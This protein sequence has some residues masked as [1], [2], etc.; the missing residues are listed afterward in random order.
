MRAVVFLLS[1]CLASARL[2]EGKVLQLDD[3]LVSVS[4]D[5]GEENCGLLLRNT[6]EL[7]NSVS[8]TLYGDTEGVVRLEGATV[9]LPAGWQCQG[10]EV[11]EEEAG[12]GDA[13]VE[14]VKYGE[15]PV[16][17]QW[18]GCGTRGLAVRLPIESLTRNDS[19]TSKRFTAEIQNYLFGVFLDAASNEV[20]III[21]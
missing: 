14:V 13:D 6:R 4:E 1:L 18:G 11:E 8:E 3:L 17:V 16:A 21:H 19:D 20:R 10:E 7:L 5:V 2:C 12:R 15:E 9:R